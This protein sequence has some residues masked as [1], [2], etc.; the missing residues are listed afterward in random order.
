MNLQ[1]F[2]I[3]MLPEQGTEKVYPKDNS[4]KNFSK[5]MFKY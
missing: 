4:S 5:V 2:G 1:D 3:L